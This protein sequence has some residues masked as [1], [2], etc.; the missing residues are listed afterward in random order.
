MG[1]IEVIQWTHTYVMGPIEVVVSLLSFLMFQWTHTYV[2]GPIEVV[3]SL[4]SFLMIDKDQ[5]MQ[6]PEIY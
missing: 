4:L 3:V 2:M 1:P 6:F 5:T